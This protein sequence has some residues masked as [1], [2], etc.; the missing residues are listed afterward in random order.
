[1][2]VSVPAARH[3]FPCVSP[4]ITAPPPLDAPAAVGECIAVFCDDQ[5]DDALSVHESKLRICLVR[6]NDELYALMNEELQGPG[7]GGVEGAEIR[8]MVPLGVVGG[9]TTYLDKFLGHFWRDIDGLGE[10]LPRG[11]GVALGKEGQPTA[12]SSSTCC[13]ALGLGRCLGRQPVSI[14]HEHRDHPVVLKQ[15]YSRPAGCK[16]AGR[17]TCRP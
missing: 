2:A 11:A 13:S 1:M 17:C 3:P 5:V 16:E 4:A 12:P 8:A 15:P 10:F 14:E 7:R 6:C 9:A